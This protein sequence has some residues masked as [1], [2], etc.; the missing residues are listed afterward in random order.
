M[1][2]YADIK[3]IECNRQQSI[4]GTSG[5]DTQPA[6]FTCRLGNTI[7]LKAGD[8]VEVMNAF[9]SE[10]GAGGETIE[11]KGES[12]SRMDLVIPITQTYEY[13]RLEVEYYDE[14]RQ[15]YAVDRPLNRDNVPLT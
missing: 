11:L 5:N 4:Q 12:P 8:T 6:Q 3:L 10:D 13:T 1:S 7:Q 15:I 2:E 9:V 14:S